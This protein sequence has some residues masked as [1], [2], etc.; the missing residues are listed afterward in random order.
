MFSRL[1]R[2]EGSW[3]PLVLRVILAVVFFPHGAQK[4]LGWF[5][6]HG[7]SGTISSFGK[8]GIPPLLAALDIIAE[9]LGPIALFIGFFTRLAALGIFVVMTV[10]ILTVHIHNGFF[11]NWTGAQKGEGFEYHLLAIAISLALAIMGGGRCSVDRAIQT[12]KAV[13]SGSG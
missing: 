4:V 9:F 2:T 11:M 13:S 1:F 3:A 12:H 10:A 6:G 8:M 7:L 5:G